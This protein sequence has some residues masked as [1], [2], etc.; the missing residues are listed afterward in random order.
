MVECKQD[1]CQNYSI[2]CK[3]SDNV[4]INA[5]TPSNPSDSSMEKCEESGLECDAL[6]VEILGLG[7]AK[8]D[9]S[10]YKKVKV[11][12]L[13]DTADEECIKFKYEGGGGK[14]ESEDCNKAKSVA[15]Y[16]HCGRYPF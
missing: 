6:G 10:I 2:G 8:I 16:A 13:K 1:S 15:C 5:H 4:W 12:K 11:E 3:F 7:N 9:I 14:L